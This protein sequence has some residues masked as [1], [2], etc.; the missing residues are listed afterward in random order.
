[1]PKKKREMAPEE[2]IQKFKDAV[3]ELVDAGELDH[4]EA[5]AAFERLVRKSRSKQ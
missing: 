1:V 5:D 3:R 4:T 2:Q